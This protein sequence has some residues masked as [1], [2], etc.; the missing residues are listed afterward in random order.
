MK[1]SN[2][3][4]TTIRLSQMQKTKT[5]KTLNVKLACQKVL[6]QR[7]TISRSSSLTLSYVVSVKPIYVVSILDCRIFN[8]LYLNLNPSFSPTKRAKSA[9]K[10]K[11]IF[12]D[13]SPILARSCLH[14]DSDRL[15]FWHVLFLEKH[16]K[17][18]CKS[19]KGASTSSTFVGFATKN[20]G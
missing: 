7:S 12:K 4:G 8:I 3:G 19:L 17:N 14:L 20:G 13:L 9:K 11:D 15:G 18:S 5:N 6:K 2:L 10:K 16:L 1:S